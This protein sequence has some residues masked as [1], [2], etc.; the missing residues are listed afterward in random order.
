MT[1]DGLSVKH[2]D[3]NSLSARESLGSIRLSASESPNMAIPKPLTPS[4]ESRHSTRSVASMSSK[5]SF[6]VPTKSTV[7]GDQPNPMP[8]PYLG[9]IQCK[10]GISLEKMKNFQNEETDFYF[11]LFYLKLLI[12][13]TNR[14]V[15]RKI[16]HFLL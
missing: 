11:V 13:A 7:R 10:N 1:D 15:P 5:V 4:A 16:R 3:N 14:G 2:S 8:N 6:N 12:W 9:E